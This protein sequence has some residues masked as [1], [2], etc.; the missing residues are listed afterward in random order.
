MINS[1]SLNAA[2]KVLP[3]INLKSWRIEGRNINLVAALQTWLPMSV[4]AQQP[5]DNIA[6]DY[7]NILLLGQI[8]R[9]SAQPCVNASGKGAKRLQ[10]APAGA[11]PQYRPISTA[12]FR[13]EYAIYLIYLIIIF[14]WVIPSQVLIGSMHDI[15]NSLPVRPW[16]ETMNKSQNKTIKLT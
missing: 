4:F 8:L 7:Q 14:N 16:P 12:R 15:C 5:R 9:Q 2:L 1:W 13:W 10:T 3:G 11:T 6:R